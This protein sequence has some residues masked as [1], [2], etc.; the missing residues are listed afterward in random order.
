M[1]MRTRVAWTGAAV[2]LSI[3]G[4]AA[5]SSSQDVSV[6]A[7]GAGGPSAIQRASVK[8]VDVQSVKFS[9]TVSASGVPGTSGT[10]SIS[11]DGTIDNANQRAQLTVDLSKAAEGLPGVAGAAI[12]SL[13]DGGQVQIVTDGPD[14]YLKLGSLASIL[15]A[16]SGQSWVKVSDKDHTGVS[17]GVSVASGSEILKLLGDTGNVTAVGPEEVRGVQTTHYR[18]TLDVA[19]AI[20]Q[21][22]ADEQ[23]QASDRLSQL[24]IDPK[25]ISF[26]VDVWIG[27]DDLVRRVQLGFDGSQL[28]GGDTAGVNAT[29]TLEFYDFGAPVDITVPS[30]DQVFNFDPGILKG[31]SG[32]PGLPGL[33]G[34][35]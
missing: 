26:P 3:G 4:L 20:G 16:T 24:G 2:A 31:L 25:S 27:E 34:G 32:L 29:V 9:L 5:C 10:A 18:G 28:P 11:A 17:T 23:Q 22:P 21:L 13:G 33:G 7:A 1:T 35:S 19:A 14:A 12:G 15:G 30:P 8:T 6:S